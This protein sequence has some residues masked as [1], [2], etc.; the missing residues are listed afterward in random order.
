MRDLPV[1]SLPLRSP[2]SPGRSS[3]STTTRC[4]TAPRD[5]TAVA[6]ER[7]TIVARVTV[8]FGAVLALAP[9]TAQG[10]E[11]A[12]FDIVSSQT[13]GVWLSYEADA[14]ERNRVAVRYLRDG[15]VRISDSARLKAGEGCALVAPHHAECLLDDERYGDVIDL[16]DRD[17]RVVLSAEPGV[18][19]DAIVAGE[20]GNDV[21]VGSMGG[22]ELRGGRGRDRVYGRGGDDRLFGDKRDMLDGGAGRDTITGGGLVRARDGRRDLIRGCIRAVADPFDRVR[23]CRRAQR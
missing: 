19:V 21:L 16:L 9:A 3:G 11:V 15:K 7:R 13:S 5:G 1:R 4:A 20:A 17:D 18:N 6:R 23:R 22:E 10:S 2:F 8:V 14:G 12:V